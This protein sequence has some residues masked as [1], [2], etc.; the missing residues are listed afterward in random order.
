MNLNPAALEPRTDSALP[1]NLILFGRVLRGLGLD[2]N[3][4]RMIDAASALA[5]VDISNRADFYHT[6]RSLLVR[7]RDDVALFDQAFDEFWKKPLMGE[8]LTLPRQQL[9]KR[10]KRQIVV[11]PP[12]ER[13]EPQPVPFLE[14]PEIETMIELT[15]IP[16]AREQLR[17]KNFAD[18][19]A[20]ELESIKRLIARMI[21][22]LGERRTRRMRAGDERAIDL[23]RTLRNSLRHGGEIMRLERRQRR[24]KPRPIVIVADIS[25]SMERYTKLLLHFVYSLTAGLDQRVESFV[26]ATRLTRITRSL[27][28]RD[29]EQALARVSGSVRDWSGGTK[30]G[31]SL[32]SFNHLWGRRVL[33][34]GA[35]VLLIS[36]GW[37][38]GE[39]EVLAAQMAR[40]RGT[41]ARVIWLNPLLGDKEYAPL[42]RGM[43]AALP[44]IDDFLPVHNL[45]SLEVLAER[46]G[47]LGS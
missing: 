6:L 3:P 29:A 41:C 9:V 47:N 4:G 33:N 42:A 40:L 36:D 10:Q 44:H 8:L 37:D 2:V 24:S 21:W 7:R 17:N 45:A 11:P 16:D 30:I 25:G 1:H 28:H 14:E 19:S 46:L 31:E 32:K 12:P 35:V 38:T 15:R 23:R 34:G 22:R 43:Q 27:E 39:P 5:H 20:Q 18:M 13:A 26:F